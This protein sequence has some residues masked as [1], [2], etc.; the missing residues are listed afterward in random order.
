MTPISRGNASPTVERFRQQNEWFATLF[1]G[2]TDILCLKDP[3][4]RWLVANQAC[5]ELFDLVGI[6][7]SGFSAEEL[8]PLA[9]KRAAYLLASRESDRRT[10]D[11]GRAYS[12]EWV[13]PM[14]DGINK[15]LEV[16]KTPLYHSDRSRKGLLVV[17][18][19][20]TDRKAAAARIQHLAHHDSLTDLPNRVLFQERLQDALAQ[21]RRH[22]GIAALILAD[23]DNFKEIN[24]TLGHAV[25]DQLLRA[26][27][28]RLKRGVRETDTVARLAADEFALVLTNLTDA[29]GAGRV[30][31]SI[32]RNLTHPYGLDDNEVMSGASLGITIFPGDGED[33]PQLLKNA[34]LALHR[35]KTEGGSRYC[36]FVAEMDEEVQRRKA[37]ERD[38]HFALNGGDQLSVAYQPLI[39]LQTG[40]IT[41][42][43][44]LCRWQ[45]P[46][47][48]AIG[49]ADFIP[50][51]ERSDLIF[52]LGRWV[53]HQVCMQLQAWKSQ[54]LPSFRV[55]VNLSPVQFR[56][57]GL[58]DMIRSVIE[59]TGADPHQ[60]QLEITETIAMR[61]FEYSVGVLRNL[62]ELGLTIAIDDF[63]TGHSSLSYLRH[64][65]V[66]K[67][68]IDRSF[69]LDLDDHP[70]SG[71]IVRA[72][73][74]LGHGIGAKVNV[75]GVE[76][77]DQLRFM[78]DHAC[79]E[80]QGFLFSR[81]L[82][83]DDYAALLAA[84]APGKKDEA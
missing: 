63:G 30:A 2:M 54:G 61:N 73:I 83:P 21:A 24:D 51:A 38:L 26:V 27:A 7:Y 10:W 17:A 58:L 44:A 13:V 45:H 65:P 53:L 67:L 5:L 18:R 70:E 43:E 8:A 14:D 25:G 37:I 52:R 36:F 56:H 22:G 66:D 11:E 81:P 74:D 57:P 28:N 49:P 47:L 48:G 9:P 84:E 23:I 72:I 39:D 42:A 82:S 29:D 50:V 79:D 40:R 77:A 31:E 68:K 4:G 12:Y 3:D 32:L 20:V 60:L 16:T 64:F 15:L 1:D 75:E 59:Q 34:D 35:A 76:T 19:N 41:G 80:C 78:N 6:E 46:T 71:A 69:V 55:A 62:R 33:G